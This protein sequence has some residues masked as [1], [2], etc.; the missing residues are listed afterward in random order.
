MNVAIRI[1][2]TRK[3]YLANVV[4][5]IVGNRIQ[6]KRPKSPRLEVVEITKRTKNEKQMPLS[7][8]ANVAIAIK[9]IKR[10]RR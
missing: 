9:T 4:Q 2:K 3:R 7:R 1:Q 8:C 5:C 10:R 6:R